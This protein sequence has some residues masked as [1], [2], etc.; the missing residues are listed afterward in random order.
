MYN[1][2]EITTKL[3]ALWY[4]KLYELFIKQNWAFYEY[5]EFY[6]YVGAFM[7]IVK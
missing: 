5:T 7:Q 6:K 2:Y 3:L 1:L 4:V